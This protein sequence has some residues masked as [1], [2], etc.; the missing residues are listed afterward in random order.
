MLLFNL[1]GFLSLARC[2]CRPCCRS[3]LSGQPAVE[4]GGL[5]FNTA[6]SFATNTNWQSYVPETTM[7]YLVQMMGL[8]VRTSSR[9][10]PALRLAIALVRGF[11]R[12]STSGIGNF[13]VDLTRCTLYVPAADLHR[14]RPVLR[15]AGR[16][17]DLARRPRR[18]PPRRRTRRSI[19]QDRS[20]R[21]KSSRCWAPTA[22]AS[23]TPTRPIRSRTPTAAHNLHPDGA[24]LR[25]IGAALTN[26]FGRM[27]G[28]AAPGLGAPR[29]HG[30]PVLAGVLAPT[31]PSGAA[32]RQSPGSADQRSA[33]Q[34]GGNME[35]QGVR[36]GIAGSAAVRHRHHRRL[37]RRSTPC[38]TASRRSAGWCPLFNIQLGEIIVG[39][40]G[41][42]LY[43]MLVCSRRR[44]VHRRL[45]VGRTPE[46]LGKKIEAKK[47]QMAMLP[48]SLPLAILVHGRAVACGA[49]AAGHAGP[50]TIPARTASGDPLR[51][52][53]RDRQQRLGLRRPHRQHA[54]LHDHLGI[55][56]FIGRF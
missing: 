25:L 8:T 26:V 18:R 27:V 35:G 31:G 46:Y 28:D 33:L 50:P 44:G 20:P 16:A 17:A 36:F 23:S 43:G 37:V 3:I 22:A 4:A 21:R 40:V 41:A 39:G 45:M 32:T 29:G 14:R 12:R 52:Y 5:A 48:S 56:M 9:R 1:V 13:W 24:D 30:D 42:G 2:A 54:L 11:A 55:A 19:A 49:V 6:M 15:L 10:R 7:S 53:L 51:L 38:T 34:A 47:C